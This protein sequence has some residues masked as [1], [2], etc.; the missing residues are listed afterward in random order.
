MSNLQYADGIDVEL[1][2]TVEMEV[3]GHRDQGQ[4]TK[5]FLKKQTARVTFSDQMNHTKVGK[6]RTMS[7]EFRVD[8]LALLRRDG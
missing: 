3:F 7:A 6:P 1:H 4:I 2:D 8:Q 5:M